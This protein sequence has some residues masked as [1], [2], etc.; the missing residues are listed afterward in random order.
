MRSL[1]SGDIRYSCLLDDRIEEVHGRSPRAAT[2]VALDQMSPAVL[3]TV[4]SLA[5]AW[6]V[7]I[8]YMGVCQNYVYTFSGYDLYCGT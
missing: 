8:T 1:T 5:S 2:P 6:Y 4:D 7:T 3:S